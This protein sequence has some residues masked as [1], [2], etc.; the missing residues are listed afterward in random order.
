MDNQITFASEQPAESGTTNG[1]PKW[2]V[3]NRCL[4][5]RVLVSS[6]NGMGC[7]CL[8][9]V[10]LQSDSTG[11]GLYTLEDANTVAEFCNLMA[12]RLGPTNWI[13]AFEAEE[14]GGE[15]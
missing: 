10:R 13:G 1:E 7:T 4:E 8:W 11:F 3:V 15:K 14:V 12:Q 6:I 2:C 9:S 5:A